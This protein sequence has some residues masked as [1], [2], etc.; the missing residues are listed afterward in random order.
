MDKSSAHPKWYQGVTAGQWLVLVVASLGWVFDAFEGQLFNITR[1]AMLADLLGVTPDDPQVKLWGDRFLAIFLAGGTLGG[2][3]FGSLGDRFGRQPVMILTI[4]FYSL[5]SGLTYLATDLWQV[6]ALRFLVAMGVGGEWAVAAALVA[7]VFPSHSRTHA[8]GIFHATGVLGTWLA[9]L[10]GMWAASEWRLAYLAG[11][12]PA[13]LTLWVRASIREPGRWAEAK[14]SGVRMG[15]FLDLFGHRIWR[16]R[17]LLGMALA[18]V[19]LGTFWGVC[20]ATQDLTR[21]LLLRQGV[22]PAEAGQKAMFAFGIIQVVGSG[23]GQLAF[24]PVCARF[25]RRRTF[26]VFHLLSFLMV[27]AVCYLPQGYGAMLLLLPLFG[28]CTY[29]SH[30]GYAIYFPE[31]FPDQLRATGASFCFNAGRLAAAPVL[32]LSGRLKQVLDLRDA[33]A[34]LGT[35]FLLGLLLLLFLPETKDQGLPGSG[36]ERFKGSKSEEKASAH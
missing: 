32:L 10:V 18:A 14:S 28:F 6:G 19:G 1:G 27:P 29:A 11:I 7:E 24:G 23:L 13:L 16:R 20:V 25:G 12:V 34:L 3:L 31:L 30:A 15:S 21:E 9:A 33:V 17:A 35:L 2:L 4:L 8:G 36:N 26:M 5:F 22:S